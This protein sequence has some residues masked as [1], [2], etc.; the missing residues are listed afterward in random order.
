MYTWD[1]SV[2]Y[3]GF[4][5]VNFISDQEKIR[6]L[7]SQVENIISLN[8]A[9]E[10]KLC[11]IIRHNESIINILNRLF[12]FV[13]LTLATDTSNEK[14]LEAYDA[15]A[16]L[17]MESTLATA[18]F[19]RYIGGI[20]NLDEIINS[21]DLLK[22][23]AFILKEEAERANHM[24]PENVETWMLRMSLSGAD[25]F[26]KLR[27]RIMGEHTVEYNG[28]T[29]PFPAIRGMAYD[30]D[31]MV[32]KSAYEA[33]IGSYE[34]IQTPMAYCL[35]NIKREGNTMAK[36]KGFNSLLEEQLYNARMDKETLDAM[37]TAIKEKLPIFQRYLIAKAKYLGH[38]N[39]LPFYDLFAPI[40]KNSLRYTPDEAKDLLI[41]TFNNVDKDMGDF[42]KECFDN[43][44][45]DLF[46]KVGK[47]GGAFCSGNHDLKQSRILCNFMG[48]FS[49]VSTL[50]HELGHGWH[51][52]CL[53]R[54]PVLLSDVPMPL[55]E[56]ASIFNETVLSHAISE[57]ADNDTEISLLDNR[58][59]EATQTVVD[60]YS[61]FL[62]ESRVVETCDSGTKKADTLNKWMT[63]AQI[64]AYGEGL[65]HNL[66]NHGMW[67]NKG[68]YYS[69]DLHF[70]NFPYAFGLLFSLLI[71]G[72]YQK[73]GK[74]FLKTYHYLLSQCGSFN[75]SDVAKQVG[76]DV[77]NVETWRM[78]LA[79]VEK[80]VEEFEKLVN[81]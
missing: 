31:A 5:D 45:I 12:N 19:T 80:D 71:Y 18:K 63:E 72:K 34:S 77:K 74:L 27:G 75:I 11:D 57:N 22:T 52:R 54:V 55:A 58:L 33:E 56:T 73:E 69:K 1:L 47:E 24:L 29:M 38:K 23:H 8:Q 50:A 32:R 30:S 70:Y 46:P 3:K 48:S 81:L 6:C 10:E 42:I 15:L 25:A 36:A 65:D 2:F 35:M 79:V 37:L 7:N 44:Y 76:I 26:S 61:R 28:E 40:G 64:E 66:L 39:G 78:A 60:I 16:Q 20:K 59:M 13:H 14:A 67:I 21:N 4:D 49:D 51:D 53:T 17:E 62:F 43:N 9:D 68:H 41:N